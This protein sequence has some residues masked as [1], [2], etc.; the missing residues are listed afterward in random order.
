MS[1]RR[2]A[3]GGS[4]RPSGPGG[5]WAVGSISP[6]LAQVH[7]R[8]H[9]GERPFQCALCRKSFTQLAHLQKHRLV[10]TGERPHKCLVSPFPTPA[11][12]PSCRPLR[13]EF[14]LPAAS[15]PNPPEQAETGQEARVGAG[16]E[17]EEDE[18]DPSSPGRA[19]KCHW[20][21]LLGSG[22]GNRGAGLCGRVIQLGMEKFLE[23]FMASC[24]HCPWV[25]RRAGTPPQFDTHR[26]ESSIVALSLSCV[27]SNPRSASSLPCGLWPV[28]SLR[29]ASAFSLSSR[30]FPST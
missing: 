24:P 11:L 17:V 5:P 14:Q 1:S 3:G 4:E 18:N 19:R 7:L 26:N 27:G 20:R 15:I 16:K 12:L 10:H 30:R 25:V 9:S 8:V 28:A 13:K 6:R 21:S 29:G 2:D 22:A 23:K